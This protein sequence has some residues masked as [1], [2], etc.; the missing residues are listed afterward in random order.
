[1]LSQF[2]SNVITTYW[3]NV[4]SIQAELFVQSDDASVT[5][6][7]GEL[8]GPFCCNAHTL[9]SRY[10]LRPCGD[11]EQQVLKVVLP[12]PCFWSPGAPFLYQLEIKVCINE[13]PE[14]SHSF[15]LGIRPLTIRGHDFFYAERRYVMRIVDV[16]QAV[17]KTQDIETALEACHETGAV[18]LMRRPDEAIFQEATQKGVLLAAQI[19]STHPDQVQSELNKYALWPAVG[20]VVLPR[21]LVL[22]MP[23]RPPVSSLIRA[24]EYR[25]GESVPPWAQVLIVKEQCLGEA[26]LQEEKRP[27]IVCC[28]LDSAASIVAARRVCDDLQQRTVAWQQIAGYLALSKGALY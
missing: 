28:P 1:L 27:Q 8:S 19:E 23:L 3:D 11:K 7:G 13:E 17:Q 24:V 18:L 16:P 6:L 5:V 12:D 2:I 21:E 10:A 9:S 22:E 15:P 4:N 20:M 25:H 26:S 14:S